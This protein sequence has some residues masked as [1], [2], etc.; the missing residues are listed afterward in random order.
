[1]E[2]DAKVIENRE[3]CASR[4]LKL[5]RGDD[6]VDVGN[7]DNEVAYKQNGT[8]ARGGRV[9]EVVRGSNPGEIRSAIR[10]GEGGMDVIRCLPAT[11][12]YEISSYLRGKVATTR[13]GTT[14][15]SS[16]TTHRRH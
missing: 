2:I 13:P 15:T 11:D 14:T 10:E 5:F 7:G 1:M 3:F 12:I 8:D 6:H 4:N 16:T 9:G